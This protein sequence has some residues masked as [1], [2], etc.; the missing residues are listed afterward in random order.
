MSQSFRQSKLLAAEDWKKIYET[1]INVNFISYDFETIKQS[2]IEYVKI[3]YSEDFNDFIESSEFIAIID[4]L[5]W[6]GE[7]LAFRVDLNTRENF[8]DTAERRESLL[9][10]AKLIGY[11][12]RRNLPAR[13]FLKI[14]G[15]QTDA[16]VI[17][18]NGNNLNG[19]RINWND[20]NNPD[21]YEQFIL[22]LNDCFLKSNIF[23]HPVQN[24]IDNNG[25]KIQIYEINNS[26]I[27]QNFGVYSITANVNNT[28][29]NFENVPFMWSRTY[30]YKELSPNP[31]GNFRIV[32]KK[33]G[34]GFNSKNTGF[35]T[36]FKQGNLMFQDFNLS[37]P[38]ENRILDIDVENI[39]DMDVWVQSINQDGSI[40]TEWVKVPST[41]NANIIYNDIDRKERNI[42]AVETKE[43]DKILI[44][45]SDGRFGNIPKGLI[46]VYFRTSANLSYVVTPSDIQDKSI[47]ISYF[48]K[49]NIPKN[50]TFY[51]SLQENITNSVPSESNDEIRTNAPQIFYSQNRMVS[52]EDYNIIPSTLPGVIKAKA[53]NRTYIGHSR[54]VDTD[55]TGNYQ[56]T[57]VIGDD[58]I[59]YSNDFLKLIE[60]KEDENNPESI[61]Y[62]VFS[63]LEREMNSSEFL[64]FTIHASK[65]IFSTVSGYSNLY[66][67][68]P[69]SG[70][71][72][73]GIIWDRITADNTFSTGRFVSKTSVIP[74]PVN[75]TAI[76]VN[77]NN[78]AQNCL[79][80][81]K[82]N[83][84]LKFKNG[85]WATVI[86]LIGNGKGP[87]PGSIGEGFNLFG[88]GMIKLNSNIDEGDELEKIIPNIRKTF[89]ENELTLIRN[90]ISNNQTFGIFFDIKTDSWKIV[91]PPISLLSNGFIIDKNYDPLDPQRNWIIL[92]NKISSYKGW[93]IYIRLKEYIYE[94]EED[95]RFFFINKHNL[96]NRETGVSVFDTIKIH[97]LNLKTITE[98]AVDWDEN[99]SY[100]KDTVVKYNKEYYIS[101][102]SGTS[103]SG[104]STTEW[105][106][107]C[108]NLDKN[109]EF[110]IYDNITYEDG[111]IEPRKVKVTFPDRNS[112]GMVD[113][114]EI[115]DDLLSSI[116]PDKNAIV[117]KKYT[118]LNGYEYFAPINPDKIF[119]ENTITSA[120]I[121]MDNDYIFNTGKESWKNNDLVIAYGLEDEILNVYRFNKENKYNFND[122]V[123]PPGFTHGD[124]KIPSDQEELD[125]N[126]YRIKFG[127]KNLI[128]L[129]KHYAPIDHRIDP[130]TVNIIDI[131]VLDKE[132]DNLMRQYLKSNNKNDQLPLP[133]TPSTLALTFQ[134]INK[135]KMISDEIIWH[136]V[137]YKLLF[138]EKAKEEL[139][140][141]IKVIKTPFSSMSDGEIKA[142]IIELLDIY[143]NPVNWDFGDTFYFSELATFIH[144]NLIND[145]SSVVLV[146]VLERSKFG[147]LYEI[148]SEYDELFISAATVDD[149]EIIQNI[150]PSNIRI[151]R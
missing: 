22:I 54:Y 115:F 67:V 146:P 41:I 103:V 90:A 109:Y 58:G 53:V 69:I 37:V 126:D 35:F 145:I 88:E 1:F 49:N 20:P 18:S 31:Y 96:P 70:P 42:Y 117:W 38:V 78:P 89:N 127:R 26:T 97:G 62:T 74:V 98:N 99:T 48:S 147:N 111:Y 59:L 55:P 8:I 102:V 40:I 45:F 14:T 46:R 72:S 93:N 149:I 75:Q 83:T 17:D 39:N 85:G 101:I 24:D 28:S 142:K 124:T 112:D 16:D 4:I 34:L 114:P 36:Y 52:G 66:I 116:N 108:S 148:K 91:F 9:K 128:F 132:Y 139:R 71:G 134:E 7:S 47:T 120:L 130:S 140:A 68:P 6:L 82:Q 61:F 95:V 86:S 15:I 138:G 25:V 30:G 51:L 12:P 105:E 13:G 11:K 143:F 84:L 150:T 141:K 81:I 5:A 135:L 77:V 87:V 80:L 29:L 129:W 10:L 122:T 3:N 136:P 56:N 110:K 63:Q 119:I 21:W 2:L 92:F 106:K 65:N 79:D 94:S 131:Y 33:D 123:I 50:V 133:P 121:S 27:N 32:Y 113:D 137:K 64:N 104:F 60:I 19:K 57:N 107:I 125:S 151:G 44:R 118:D 76:A 43:S 144:Q 23:G 73:Q 100:A